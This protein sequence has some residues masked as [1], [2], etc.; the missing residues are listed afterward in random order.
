MAVDKAMSKAL[1]R[2]RARPP[3]AV[4]RLAGVAYG[5]VLLAVTVL[6]IR[7]SYFPCSGEAR[8]DS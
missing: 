3:S 5:A 4:L 2:R 6:P 8:G 7:W 1:T